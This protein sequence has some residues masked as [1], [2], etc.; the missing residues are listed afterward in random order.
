MNINLNDLAKALIAKGV[1]IIPVGKN[2]IPLISWKEFQERRAT[3]DEVD[4]WFKNY[5]NAQLGIVTGK[6]SDLSVVDIENGGDPSFLPSNTTIVKTGGGGWHYYYKYSPEASTKARIRPLVD[7]RSDGGYVVAPGSVS[8]K[9]EYTII[10]SI[11]N[12]EFPA[13]LFNNNIKKPNSDFTANHAIDDYPGYGEGQRNDQMTR[14]IGYVLSRVHPS[15]WEGEAWDIIRS[16]N[17]KNNPPLSESELMNSFNS[18]KTRE[19]S[20][21]PDRWSKK[22]EEQI[23]QM[24]ETLKDDTLDL[25]KNVADVQIKELNTSSPISTGIRSV[26]ESLRG[27]FRLGDLVIVSGMTGH[28][29]TTL[30]S[31]IAVNMAERGE[32]VLFL[33][34]EV[35]VA[36]VW[37][38]IK[39]MGVNDDIKIY[40][41]KCHTSG[42][43]AWIAKK[44]KEAK[45]YG[46]K[47]IVIDHLEFLT[48][49]DK[50][51]KNVNLNFSNKMSEVVKEVKNLARNEGVCILLLCHLR[52]VGQGRPGINDLKDTS[53]IGQESD[54]VLFIERLEVAN[55]ANNDDIYSPLSVLSI[56]KNRRTG[57]TCYIEIIMDRGRFV[58]TLKVD[59]DKKNES[60]KMSMG[61][62]D[63]EIEMVEKSAI[64]GLLD[65][66]FAPQVKDGV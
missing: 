30:A 8:E 31:T 9:G 3:P 51:A 56:Q 41:P 46:I 48:S 40:T 12:A 16:A 52:K 53:S 23:K 25:M 64:Q 58:E 63:A 29:K 7:L 59:I 44:I 60:A 17:L 22:T 14:Y 57:K 19:V 11:P 37:D 55:P 27:G 5:P 35:F 38:K 32:P 49:D 47:F 28:G 1:S 61:G 18:I 2:K 10:K 54:C 6:I 45:A 43:I 21:Y 26:D 13:H 50:Y 33:T 20:A 62:E 39:A 42:R 36:E 24:E 34:Y 4:L 65:I 15:K 66:G